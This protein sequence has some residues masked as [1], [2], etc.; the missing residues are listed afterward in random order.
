MLKLA[1][2]KGPL[3]LR[4]LKGTTDG[5]FGPPILCA[6]SLHDDGTSM[7]ARDDDAEGHF[8]TQLFGPLHSPKRSLRTGG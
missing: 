3:E 1:T 8:K 5:H 4:I 7:W 6:E 2:S